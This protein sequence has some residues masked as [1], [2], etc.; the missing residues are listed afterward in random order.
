MK[1]IVGLGN[2]G[3]AYARSRHNVGFL[4]IDGLS[5]RSGIRLSER[6][7]HVVLGQGQDRA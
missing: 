1:L 3:R 7:K 6:R 5:S 2:P 4:C